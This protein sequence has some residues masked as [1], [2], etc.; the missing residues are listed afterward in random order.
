MSLNPKIE[1]LLDK[2]TSTNNYL[3]LQ[4]L[5]N[6][7]KYSLE[8]ALKAIIYYHLNNWDTE[9]DYFDLSIG[10][11]CLTYEIDSYSGISNN[12]E[13]KSTIYLERGLFDAAQNIEEHTDDV[14][15]IRVYEDL[16]YYYHK[17]DYSIIQDYKEPLIKDLEQAIPLFVALLNKKS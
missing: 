17:D 5:Q 14:D 4:L 15:Y 2:N 8:E 7:E 6:S 1:L 13:Q 11:V 9:K 16:G 10:T 12:P 3:V